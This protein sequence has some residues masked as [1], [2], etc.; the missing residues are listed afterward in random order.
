[1]SKNYIMKSGGNRNDKHLILYFQVHQPRR[2]QAVNF[3]DLA[4][5]PR[6]FDDAL[7]K[8]IIQRVA[9][10]C[11][12]PANLLLLDLVEKF[13]AIKITFSLS[14]VVIEQLQAYAPEALD[15]FCR[16]AQTGSVEFLAETYYHSLACLVHTDEFEVQVLM[17]AEKIFEVFGLRPV[18]FRN[19]ELIYSDEVGKRVAG[20]GFQGIFTEGHENI[21]GSRTPHALY[22]HPEEEH[23]KLFLRNYRLSDGIAFRFTEG[24]SRLSLR[25]YMDLLTRIPADEKLVNLAVDYETF[26]VHQKA[27]TG[28]FDFLRNFLETLATSTHYAMIFPSEAVRAIVPASSLSVESH[29]SGAD[30]GRD[31]S[32]WLGNGMQKDAFNSLMKLESSLKNPENK[33]LLRYWRYLQTSDHLYYMSVKTDREGSAHSYFSP[34]PSSYE[35]FTNFMNIVTHLTLRADEEK[36]N[37]VHDDHDLSSREA[38]RQNTKVTT[39]VWVMNLQSVPQGKIPDEQR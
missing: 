1:M 36:A 2:L 8:S 33:G 15:S 25:Q 11:Y 13:P 14:G 21:L 26:G 32:A 19:T 12:L 9:R 6:Y 34:F 5:S 16:L 38:E 4:G 31:L 10:D 39:P 28:I 35:A 27:A 30:V 3:F 22:A 24:G 20:M 17:H 23:L 7:N 18:V 37:P 29:L